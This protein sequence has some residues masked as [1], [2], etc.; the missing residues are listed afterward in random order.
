MYD[1]IYQA[2]VR[3]INDPLK[4]GRI[5]CYCPGIMGE[6]DSTDQWLSWATPNLPFGSDPARESGSLVVPPLNSSVNLSFRSGNPDFPIYEGSCSVGR[7]A[8]TSSVPRLA[9]G[10]EDET[11]GSVETV[12]G[13]SVPK[14]SGGHSTYPLNRM[15]R[16]PA[17][18]VV[19]LDDTTGNRRIRIRHSDGTFVELRNLGDLLFYVVSGIVMYAAQS[20]KIASKMDI[21][22]AVGIGRKVKLGGETGAFLAV[23]RHTDGVTIG[24]LAGVVTVPGVPAA[25]PV[26]FTYIPVGSLPQTLIPTVTLS[27]KVVA[28]SAT[29]ESL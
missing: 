14:S 16:T 13:V 12:A 4:L 5:R 2:F 27:G 26:S 10:D 6:E 7:G 25:I 28:T 23:A 24:T 20:I 22:L 8:A 29:T 15:V 17:G 21:I 19:E 3:D 9:K 11:L 18:H 1:S